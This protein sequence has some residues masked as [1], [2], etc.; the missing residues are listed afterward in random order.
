M[1]DINTSNYQAANSDKLVP[2]NSDKMV[3]VEISEDAG[4]YILDRG[5]A[6]TMEVQASF[7]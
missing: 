3:K 4:R 5:G 6:I 2:S 7:G 1:P